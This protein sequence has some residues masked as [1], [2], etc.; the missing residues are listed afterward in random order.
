MMARC[1][2]VISSQD[3]PFRY[4]LTKGGYASVASSPLDSA[5]PTVAERW[6]AKS[7][8]ADIGRRSLF[9][10]G[11]GMGTRDRQCAALGIILVLS[12]RMV[13]SDMARNHGSGKRL[14]ILRV[15]C[16][17]RLLD[18]TAWMDLRRLLT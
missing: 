16:R 3:I 2:S 8:A 11:L 10:F 9:V 7:S 4:A 5:V 15:N 13:S 18:G 1:V 17:C 14:H 6:Q 12:E